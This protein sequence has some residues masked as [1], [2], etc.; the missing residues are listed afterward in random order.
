M[1]NIVVGQSGG[2]TAVINASLAG[3]IEA[4]KAKGAEK[5][6][7]MLNGIDGLI[8]GKLTLLYDRAA[9]KGL[10]AD[11]IKILKQTPA[12]YLGSTRHKMKNVEEAEAE[13]KKIF[14]NLEKNKIDTLILIGGNDTADTTNSMY[15]YAVKT[16]GELTVIG[17][18]KT[19][20][21][22]LAVTDHA[23]GFGSAAKY[24]ATTVRELIR[25][26]YSFER[27]SVFIIEIM[28]RNAGWL[29]AAAL[30]AEDDDNPGPDIFLY[31][32]KHF[33][34]DKFFADIKNVLSKK[35]TVVIAASEGIKDVNEIEVCNLHAKGD[36]NIDDH[37]H[38][39]LSGVANY[40]K[41]RVEQQLKKD[42]DLKNVSAIEFSYIQRS[43]AHI[44]SGRDVDDAYLAGWHAV[45]AAAAGESGKMVI[46]DREPGKKGE[47][48]TCKAAL[49]ANVEHRLT[50]KWP[51]LDLSSKEF[52]DAF[53][54]YAKPLIKGEIHIE[55]DEKTGLPKHLV[56]PKQ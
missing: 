32:E 7:G 46:L 20:D 52:R 21:N 55:T 3:V 17:V 16:G 53:V 1:K 56:L 12:A 43:A 44:A 10:T 19:I 50:D 41:L 22:D 2:P 51:D 24:V 36:K 5:V 54:K 31:P 28:G 29:T 47:P 18:P 9:D 23:P 40:L 45:E 8:H 34:E 35:N 37:G 4:A 6:F 38:T 15:N 49:I 30:L 26:A 33:N 14:A 25:D 27:K 48:K 39:K 13:Y 11:E 42:L